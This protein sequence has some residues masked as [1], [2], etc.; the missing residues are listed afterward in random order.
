MAKANPK[1]KAPRTA[2]KKGNKGGPGRPPK[3]V[4]VSELQRLSQRAG[5][6]FR[7]DLLE[8]LKVL[9]LDPDHSWAALWFAN[10]FWP[11]KGT[12]EALNPGMEDDRSDEDP[13]G[14]A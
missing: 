5:A 14:L 7:D 1:R 12:A 13:E 2:F 11:E 10:R 3:A 4:E 6:V 9:A 8:H